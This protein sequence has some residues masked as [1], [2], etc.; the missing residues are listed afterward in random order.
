MTPSTIA[1][2]ALIVAGVLAF[3]YSL[4]TGNQVARWVAIGCV[5]GALLLRMI[6]RLMNRG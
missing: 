2:L 5:V 3:G 1:R 4:N 6:S